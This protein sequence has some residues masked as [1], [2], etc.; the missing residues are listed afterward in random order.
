MAKEN[1]VISVTARKAA[2]RVLSQQKGEF[3]ARRWGTSEHAMGLAYLAELCGVGAGTDEE[4]KEARKEFAKEFVDGWSF[5]SNFAR[6]K[7]A[8]NKLIP[9]STV[10]P[11]G[12]YE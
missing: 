3:A 9:E 5:A 12:E 7:L 8:P 10:K 6:N 1:S 2:E 4:Q 11:T